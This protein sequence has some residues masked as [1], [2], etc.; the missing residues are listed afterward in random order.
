MVDAAGLGKSMPDVADANRYQAFGE[1]SLPIV[2]QP[3]SAKNLNVRE[4]LENLRKLFAEEDMQDAVK[5][6]QH[7]WMHEE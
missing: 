4:R 2:P 6:I 1:H 3:S 5:D 7:D